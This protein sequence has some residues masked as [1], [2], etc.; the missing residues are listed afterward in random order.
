[1]AEMFISMGVVFLVFLQ[2]TS[3]GSA[4]EKAPNLSST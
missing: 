3:K 1:M 4:I 2:N